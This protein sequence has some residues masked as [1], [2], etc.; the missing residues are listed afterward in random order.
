MHVLPIAILSVASSRLV[1]LWHKWT[2]CVC[3]FSVLQEEEHC[4]CVLLNKLYLMLTNVS[5]LHLL[6]HVFNIS[7][8][9]SPLAY[10]LSLCRSLWLWKIGDFIDCKQKTKKTTAAA[11]TTVS[12]FR[13]EMTILQHYEAEMGDLIKQGHTDRLHFALVVIAHHILLFFLPFC[14]LLYLSYPDRSG[15]WEKMYRYFFLFG[16]HLRERA[17][18]TVTTYAYK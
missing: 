12:N 14:C 3:F 13:Y 7:S 1:D 9:P 15:R 11:T 2:V 17:D 5:S 18:L 8:S 6:G 4:K 10:H 16:E